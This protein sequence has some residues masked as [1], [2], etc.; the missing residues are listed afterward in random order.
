VPLNV[1]KLAFFQEVCD[2]EA[3]FGWN[4]RDPFWEE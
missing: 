4:Y 2:T 3:L 1:G